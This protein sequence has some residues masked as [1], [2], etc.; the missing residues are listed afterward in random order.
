MG[1]PADQ[2][3]I[4]EIG[5][6]RFDAHGDAKPEQA[7]LLPC[8]GLVFYQLFIIDEIER[9]AQELGVI[10]AIIGL[11]GGCVVGKLVGLNKVSL[12]DFQTVHL[13]RV[14]DHVHHPLHGKAHEGFA[15]A[16]IGHH[17]T[18]I[19]QHR[20]TF[21]GNRRH[22]IAVYDVA[23]HQQVVAPG[24]IDTCPFV[25]DVTKLEAKNCAV[26]FN[27]RGDVH[28]A[29]RGMTEGQQA[30][31]PILDPFHRSVGLPREQR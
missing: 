16:P 30:F 27:R 26:G 5:S 20:V 8:L 18:A 3:S 9:L 1:R 23:E 19:G 28:D 31:A 4:T 25:F 21:V 29:V 7:P 12:A 6:S 10:S 17:R 22:F 24:K 15:D 2:H 13:E 14:G 11:A